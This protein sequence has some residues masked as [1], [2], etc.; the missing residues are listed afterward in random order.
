VDVTYNQLA[1]GPKRRPQGQSTEDFGTV[2]IQR[3]HPCVVPRGLHHLHRQ[4]RAVE[5]EG[6]SDGNVG[7]W[8]LHGVT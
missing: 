4:P 5:A 1:N 3:I 6:F 7:K 8:Y 2:S